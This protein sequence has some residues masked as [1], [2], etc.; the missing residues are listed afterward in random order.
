MT[1]AD[2]LILTALLVIVLIALALLLAGGG[3]LLR[4]I[5]T[6][7]ASTQEFERPL[8]LLD[9]QW[10]LESLLYRHHRLSGTVIIVASTF[11]LWQVIAKDLL[12]VWPAIGLWQPLWWLL[13]I[14]NTFNLV[15]GLIVVFRPSQLKPV[16]AIAN[17]WFPVD[18]RHLA[19]LLARHPRLR[20]LILLV[21]ALV[22]LG[23]AGLLLI[24][25]VQVIG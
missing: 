20:G 18:S 2:V 16:E 3:L 10:H 8:D 4:S 23:G 15:I 19:R 21:I 14:G 5:N 12:S 22:A 7:D 24:E 1:A 17:R 11:F 25:R 9:R 6:P 13:I